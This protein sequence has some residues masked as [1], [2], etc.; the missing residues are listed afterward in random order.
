MRK[1]LVLRSIPFSEG[2][3]DRRVAK[4]VKVCRKN[5]HSMENGCI[6]QN[7]VSHMDEGDFFGSEKSILLDN[8][9][10]VEIRFRDSD[11]Q[12]P[13]SKTTF[14]SLKVK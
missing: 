6:L 2:N 11:E 14:P 7:S 12:T 9:T 3:S 4:P 10:I 13:F 1:F 5:P 8:E